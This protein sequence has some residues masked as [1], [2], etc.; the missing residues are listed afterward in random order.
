LFALFWVAGQFLSK[1]KPKSIVRNQIIMRKITEQIKQAFY[2]GKA[3]SVG[4]TKTDGNAVYLHGHKIIE[5]RSDG[6]YVSLAGW[7]TPTTR[8]RING[9]TGAGFHQVKFR[10]CLNNKRVNKSAW[11]KLLG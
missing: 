2:A 8:E 11:Y 3:K 7:D 6:I 1:H 5:R 4:N 10:T 9:I